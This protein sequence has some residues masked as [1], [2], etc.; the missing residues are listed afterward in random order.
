[1]RRIV[2]SWIAWWAL[3]AALY[4]LLADNVAVPELAVGA[5]AAAIGATG[6]VLVRQQRQVLLRPRA[7]WLRG[8]WRPLIGLVGDL[9]PLA[10]VLVE[11]GILRR[12]GGG[13][14]AGV[15][16]EATG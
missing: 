12:G 3:L 13:G 11:R 7:R 4:L 16:F 2:L 8:A 6:A 14:L 9:V 10:R 15:P 5:A 1:M